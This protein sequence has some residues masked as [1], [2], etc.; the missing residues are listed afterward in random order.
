MRYIFSAFSVSEFFIYLTIN[1]SQRKS[2]LPPFLK[3][4]SLLSG[5]N[6]YTEILI[7][8]F[9]P[10]KYLYRVPIKSFL[11]QAFLKLEFAI[12]YQ[13]FIFHQMIALLKL[14]KNFFFHLKSPFRSRDIQMFV[15]MSSP[16]FLSFSHCFRGFSKLNLKVYDIIT[17]LNRNLITHF[18]WYLGKEKR[19]DIETLTIDRVLNKKHFYGILLYLLLLYPELPQLQVLMLVLG[20]TFLLFRFPDPCILI[21]FQ[22]SRW[23]VFIHKK[24]QLNQ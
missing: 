1:P 5:G 3:F 19:Y 22:F 23:Q 12:F 9:F 10:L 11:W 2:F 18:V 4:Q 7:W 14:W 16:L 21:F 15:F 20:A 13:I 6:W 8:R 24:H 17:C